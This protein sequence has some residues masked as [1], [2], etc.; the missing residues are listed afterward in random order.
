MKEQEQTNQKQENPPVQPAK[1]DLSGQPTVLEKAAQTI[2][3]D[4]KLMES[5]LKILL[6]PITLITGVGLIIFWFH[7]MNDQ[8]EEINQLKTENKKLVDEKK[9][10]EDEYDKLKKKYK[11]LKEVNE[12]E[13]E[14]NTIGQSFIP[15]QVQPVD[16][17]KKKTYRSA[18]LD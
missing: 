7:K 15:M 3:G 13:T 12:T 5:V 11:K 18:Y 10:Q 16:L 2:A 4:N 1:K 8:K 9:E 6:S 17:A 14:N